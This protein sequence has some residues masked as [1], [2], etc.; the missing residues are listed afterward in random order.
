[1]IRP[2]QP[3][4][5]DRLMQIWLEAN[6]EAHDFIP[7]QYW[8]D[9]VPMVREA[10]PQAWLLVSEQAETGEIQGF[11]GL[12]DDFIAGLFVDSRFRGHG[13]GAELLAAARTFHDRLQLQVYC[14]NTGA[15]RFYLRE[16]F[17]QKE[18][19]LENETGQREWTML[20]ER[21][22]QNA[23]DGQKTE[24]VKKNESCCCA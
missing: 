13:I 18:E 5:L 9:H 3:S 6:R 17:V 24:S 15:V 12:M 21:K 11:L 1:M 10:L 2:Y 7:E 4:D 14:R 19:D 23:R 20:W 8:L 22:N 16:G